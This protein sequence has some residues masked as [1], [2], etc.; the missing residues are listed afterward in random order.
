MTETLSPDPQTVPDRRGHLAGSTD[1]L[2]RGGGSHSRHPL[3]PLGGRSV[4]VEHRPHAGLLQ[5]ADPEP[6]AR[7]LAQPCHRDVRQLAAHHL[8]AQGRERLL[9]ISAKSGAAPL[10]AG[11]ECGELAAPGEQVTRFAN[12]GDKAFG[13][14]SCPRTRTARS[15][16]SVRFPG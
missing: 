9:D 6:T 4:Y 15:A 5:R 7:C 1:K 13:H 12:V 16:G 14:L 2:P 11:G 10:E 8:L 3:Q